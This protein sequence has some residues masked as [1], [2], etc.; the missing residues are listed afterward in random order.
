MKKTRAVLIA[1]LVINLALVCLL[2]LFCRAKPHESNGLELGNAVKLYDEFLRGERSVELGDAKVRIGDIFRGD[3]WDRYALFDMNG[4]GIPELHVRSSGPYEIISYRDG[5]L[6]PWESFWSYSK[7]LN[8]GALLSERPGGAN[9]TIAYAY[10]VFDSYGS[11]QLCVRFEKANPND[12]GAYDE[13]SDYFFEDVKVSMDEWNALTGKYLS[14]GS[15][16]IE[17]MS[18]S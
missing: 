8:N 12:D 18:L 7:P 1:S 5:E 10:S 2:L 11:E 6:V 13:N 3:E 9:S 17:W 4:D 16:E 14:V 15:D